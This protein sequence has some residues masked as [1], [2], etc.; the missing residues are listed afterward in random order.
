[1]ENLAPIDTS[2]S[3]ILHLRLRENH[4]RGDGKIIRTKISG[5]LLEMPAQTRSGQWQYQRTCYHGVGKVSQASTQ[6]KNYRQ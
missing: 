4:R 2:T 5:N 3:Q 6:T 1:M